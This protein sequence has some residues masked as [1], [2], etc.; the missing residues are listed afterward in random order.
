MLKWR[1]TQTTLDTETA[2]ME[3][4]ERETDKEANEQSKWE[5]LAPYADGAACDKLMGQL[6]LYRYIADVADIHA[7]IRWINKTELEKEKEKETE[8]KLYLNK[9][10]ILPFFY[11]FLRCG[12][13]NC[14]VKDTYFNILAQIVDQPIV[15]RVF[16]K[17]LVEIVKRIPATEAMCGSAQIGAGSVH[18]TDVGSVM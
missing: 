11:R 10:G 6:E 14:V 8:R 4:I 3:K 15:D 16:P 17:G 1:T 12:V 2:M 5:S 9:D 7:D 18:I 13:F